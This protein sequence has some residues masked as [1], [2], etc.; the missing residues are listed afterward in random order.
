MSVKVFLKKHMCFYFTMPRVRAA[1]AATACKA[2]KAWALFRFWA[3]IRSYKIQRVKT[4]WGR[5]LDLAW[6]KFAV[7]ALYIVHTK[8]LA[9]SY[10]S[11][12]ARRVA[13]R[14]KTA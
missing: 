13:T 10:F 1:T 4:I 11:V 7:A 6:L 9:Q 12:I 8:D 5:I 14:G 3:S 2:P